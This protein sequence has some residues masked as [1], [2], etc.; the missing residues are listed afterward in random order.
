MDTNAANDNGKVTLAL[1]GQ[2]LDMLIRSVDKLE[3]R[4]AQQNGHVSC[5][6]REGVKREER[7]AELRQDVDR[8]NNRDIWGTIG[9][10][11]AAAVAAIIA[12]FR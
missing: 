5:L 8:L 3:E 4:L 7:I 2:K 6:E 10:G 11:M 1:I 12:W 9:A